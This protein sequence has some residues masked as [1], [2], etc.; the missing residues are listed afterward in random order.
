ME[1]RIRTFNPFRRTRIV[2]WNI[3]LAYLTGHQYLG[4]D[5]EQHLVEA[6]NSRFRST[7]NKL[8]PAVRN[9]VAMATKVPP[10]FDIVPDTTD[11]DDRATAI[12]GEEMASYLRKLNHFDEQRGL[13]IIWYDI[14]AIAWRKQ[15]WDPFYKVVGQNPEPTLEDGSENPEHNPDA[16]V[17]EPLYDGEALSE[18]VPTNE[19][20]WDWR[21]KT[22]K[23]SWIIHARPMTYGEIK[24]QYGLEKAN[25]IPES[26]FL[27][28]NTGANEF[29][30]KIFTQFMSF[31]GSTGP[32]PNPDTSDM[33]KD[34][35]QVMVYEFWQVIDGNYT[36]GVL[37][38]MAGFEPGV[39]LH[40][41]PYPIDIYP[42]GE[43]PFTGYDM[44]SPDKAVAGT[45]S[46]IS[47]AR[48]LQDELNEVRTHIRE[49][50]LVMGGGTVYVPRGGK[51]DQKRMDNGPGLI[52]EY[53][54]PYR[55][56]K[57]GG[58]PLSGDAFVYQDTIIRDINDIF[59]FPQVAQGKR[60]QGGPKSGVG[61]ALLQEAATSQHSP[62]IVQM[63]RKDEH[64]MRQ[65][66]SIAFANY[67][68]RTFQ[69]VGKDNQWTLFEF[70]PQSYTTQFNVH[71]RT[72]SSLPISKAIERD[73]TLALL[74][75]GLLG[76]PQDPTV[77]KRT[78]E[79]IDI[80]GLDKI[81]RD[82]ARETNFAKLEYQTP[83]V[84]YR[85]ALESGQDAKTAI[86]QIYLPAVNIF[87][88]HDIHVIEH[89]NDLLDRYFEYLGSGDPGLLIIAQAQL[90]H[91]AQHSEILAE[92]QLNQAI[93]SGTIKAEDLESSQEKETAKSDNEPKKKK[94]E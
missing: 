43:V 1:S 66:M 87:D 90:A 71:V 82:N 20:I 48:P 37:G 93:L 77:R 91:Y 51:V 84:R 3:N 39:I 28:P 45:S 81:L 19:L 62:I 57:E 64:A 10:K 92:Q 26:A 40:N 75:T 31:A 68:K 27:D 18:H 12:A 76:N 86:A 63:D 47:M 60:P 30:M 46:R 35:R 53:D 55:P 83:V 29:E 11:E 89:K 32:T 14:A 67:G 79:T 54:G 74:Q 58:V 33:R 49:N 94:K 42:H 38:V 65:L 21:Q 41:E 23:L 15:Y 36:E 16:L 80:G 22:E 61:V 34:D 9:D 6:P 59:S 7:V 25:E 73:T 78:L 44:M 50:F 5:G 88:N 13:L 69:I 4:L 85:Q 17:G 52:V 56:Q 70:D 72:G 2:E 24:T 8:A